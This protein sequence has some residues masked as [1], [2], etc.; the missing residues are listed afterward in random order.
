M[1]RNEDGMNKIIPLF[2]MSVGDVLRIGLM[3][4][5]VVICIALAIII[6]MQ[7]SKQNGLSG[8]ISGAADSSWGKNKGRSMEGKL[9]KITK[10]LVVLFV[11]IA[12]ILNFNFLRV[13]LLLRV[14]WCSPDILMVR[15]GYKGYGEGYI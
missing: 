1:R 15:K 7:E 5:F 6:L 4:V 8:T 3:G 12:V 9:V 11:V 2:H 13:F 14:I 10:I